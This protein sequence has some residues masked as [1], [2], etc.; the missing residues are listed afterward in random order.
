MIM[1][2]IITS[3]TDTTFAQIKTPITVGMDHVGMNVPDMD[4]A[5][6]FF[7]DIMG[8]QK[9]TEIGPLELDD[10]WKKRYHIRQNATV[11]K[12]VMM[13]AGNGSSIELFRYKSPERTMERPLGDDVGWFH[14]GFYTDDIYGS[15][16]YLRSKGVNVLNDPIVVTEGPNKGETW[17]YFVTPWGLQIELVSYAAGKEYEK[18]GAKVKLWSPKDHRSEV[19]AV[20]LSDQKAQDLINRH[21]ELWSQRDAGK[22]QAVIQEIYTENVK[23]TDPSFIINGRAGLDHFIEGLQGQ[24]PG[25]NFSV[26]KPAENHH[27]TAR[28]NWQFGPASNPGAIK[29]QDIFVFNDGRISELYVFLEA[30]EK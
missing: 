11:E 30:P 25:Y 18:N 8:F 26:L 9:V 29:G 19:A 13:R 24:H 16:A 10:A 17:A 21:I 23:V 1:A 6:Q 22:R 14:I 20:A 3:A 15:V 7:T 2:T 28:L 4:Q 5:L 12:I 27:N